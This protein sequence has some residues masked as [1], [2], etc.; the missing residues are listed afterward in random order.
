MNIFCTPSIKI[1]IDAFSKKGSY[2]NLKKELFLFFN[3]IIK[4]N[5]SYGLKLNGSSPNPFY[6]KRINGSGGYRIY[7]YA[8]EIKGF[9][10]LVALHPKSG[11][12]GKSNLS[13]G[14]IKEAQESFISCYESKNYFK[15]LLDKNKSSI[16]F[17]HIRDEKC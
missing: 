10:F 7:Y 11:K 1:D 15:V 16:N 17:A 13:A 5:K 4:G 9:I 8:F 3:L 6:K 2:K 12:K 14:E